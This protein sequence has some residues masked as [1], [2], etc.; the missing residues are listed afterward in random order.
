MGSPVA[1]VST[2]ARGANDLTHPGWLAL[3]A[4]VD[5]HTPGSARLADIS[6]DTAEW[7]AAQIAIRNTAGLPH[8]IAAAGRIRRRAALY[9]KDA[10]RL[11]AAAGTP[12]R[13]V[14]ASAG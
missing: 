2:P 7:I 6:A 10:R 8:Q 9:R 11:R 5:A 12:A 3:L 4:D 1:H 13:V 14:A